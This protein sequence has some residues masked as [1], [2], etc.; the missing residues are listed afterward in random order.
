MMKTFLIT[1]LTLLILGGCFAQSSTQEPKKEL[2]K[3]NEATVLPNNNQVSTNKK[4]IYMPVMTKEQR[5]NKINNELIKQIEIN[6]NELPA[7]K[8]NAVLNNK[9]E[10]NPA[11]IKESQSN[12]KLL[13]IE[14]K[15]ILLNNTEI[16]KVNLYKNEKPDKN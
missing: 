10:I 15:E 2:A 7:D 9:K 4:D 16:E 8:K 14:S 12:V 6:K 5:V 13:K 1:V 3:K 11:T